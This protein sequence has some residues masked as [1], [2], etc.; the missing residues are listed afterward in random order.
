MGVVVF[1]PEFGEYA[2]EGEVLLLHFLVVAAALLGLTGADE[3]GHA[4]EDLVGPAKVLEDEVAVVDFE[5]PVVELVLLGAPVPLQPAPRLLR[6]L[7]PQAAPPLLLPLLPPPQPDVA[8][9]PEQRLEVVP[10]NHLLLA[11]CHLRPLPRIPMA[12]QFF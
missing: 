1:E 10:R 9:L 4:L 11:L 2:V 6:L 8:L 12:H 3:V 5:E 7:H